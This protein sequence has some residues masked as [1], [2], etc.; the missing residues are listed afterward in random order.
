MLKCRC[1]A[2]AKD[3]APFQKWAKG[4]LLTVQNAGRRRTFEEAL[5]GRC[6]TLDFRHIEWRNQKAHWYEAVSFA[7]NSQLGEV[8]QNLFVL[9]VVKFENWGRLAELLRF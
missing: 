8:S 2:K 7:L 4:D 1:G 5:R 6:N 9:G 3:S